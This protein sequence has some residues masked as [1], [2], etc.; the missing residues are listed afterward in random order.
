MLLGWDSNPKNDITG[1]IMARISQ[2]TAV[3]DAYYKLTQNPSEIEE[4]L[5]ESLSSNASNQKGDTSSLDEL[6]ELISFAKDEVQFLNKAKSAFNEVYS[7]LEG[8]HSYLKSLNHQN[9][10]E[11]GRKSLKEKLDGYISEINLV[12]ENSNQDNF[13][14]E[15]ITYI[16]K[17]TAVD[18]NDIHKTL[19]DYEV[20]AKS[21]LLGGLDSNLSTNE[22]I[23]AKKI[24]ISGHRGSVLNL[25]QSAGESAKTLAAEIAAKS[26][27]I[28]V[29]VE[30]RN[31]L[32]IA[33]LSA[34]GTFSFKLTNERTGNSGHTISGINIT[35][36]ANLTPLYNAINNSYSSTAV[37]AEISSQNS[38]V[39][40]IDDTGDTINLTSITEAAGVKTFN[41]F[42][43]YRKSSRD[44]ALQD[45]KM[46]FGN[47]TEHAGGYVEFFGHDK[48]NIEN[49]SIEK[50]DTA[51][52]ILGKISIVGDQVS[53]GT[54]I[55]S[56]PIGYIHST[57]NGENGARLR[58]KF[59]ETIF[60]N[61]D[62][63]AGNI[64]D[65]TVNGW[66]IGNQ[67][68]VFGTDQIGGLNTPSDNSYPLNNQGQLDAGNLA[69]GTFAS[70]LVNS[71]QA[72]NH[73]KSLK[74]ES[75]NMRTTVYGVQHGG[76][77]NQIARGPFVVSN[78]S[79]FLRAGEEVSF[80]WKATGGADAYDVYGYL[81]NS[82]TN[83]FITILNQ[84]GGDNGGGVSY[85]ASTNWAKSSTDITTSGNYKF[86]FASGTYDETGGLVMG[87][88]LEIDNIEITPGPTLSV[89]NVTLQKIADKITLEHLTTD[90]EDQ[91]KNPRIESATAPVGASLKS[92]SI[93]N[94]PA[95]SLAGAS[96]GLA[97]THTITVAGIYDTVGESIDTRTVTISANASAKLVSEQLNAQNINTNVGFAAKTGMVI[98]AADA[99]YNDQISFKLSNNN[100]GTADIAANI[101][102]TNLN[103]LITAI[104]NQTGTTGISATTWQGSNATLLLTHGSGEDIA[105]GELQGIGVNIQPTNFDNTTLEAGT[106][107]IT[108]QAARA[109]MI[110]PITDD[111]RVKITAATGAI[112]ATYTITGKNLAGTNITEAVTASGNAT[113]YS[114]NSFSTVTQVQLSSPTSSN[115]TVGIA[116]DNDGIS[117][118]SPVGTSNLSISGTLVSSGTA[119]LETGEAVVIDTESGTAIRNFTIYGNNAQGT[120]DSEVITSS[121]GSSVSTSK[122][123]TTVTRI[124]IDGDLSGR[125]K[126]GIGSNL[127]GIATIQNPGI[128][129]TNLTLNGSISNA[130]PSGTAVLVD[131]EAV[132]ISTAANGI[133][134]AYT[135]SGKD[136]LGNSQTEVISAVRGATRSG[137]SRFLTVSQVAV[138][139]ISPEGVKIG[140]D[141]DVD[142]I[143]TEADYQAAG[144]AS[145]NGSFV[146]GSTATLNDSDYDLAI[147]GTDREGNAINE[148]VNINNASTVETTNKFSTITSIGVTGSGGNTGRLR[149]FA[150]HDGS[151]IANSQVPNSGANM[152]LT[153][154]SFQN[155]SGVVVGALEA[156]S[157]QRFTITS[158][159]NYHSLSNISDELDPT[160]YSTPVPIDTAVGLKVSTNRNHEIFSTGELLVSSN[161]Q[162][163]IK[164]EDAANELKQVTI[165]SDSSSA[166]VNFT[167]TGTDRSGKSLSETITSSS[168]ATVTG[169][170]SFAIITDVSVDA[171][172]VGNVQVGTYLDQDGIAQSQTRNSAGSLNMNGD[173]I[174][175]GQAVLIN[176]GST[177]FSNATNQNEILLENFSLR[178]TVSDQEF[179]LRYKYAMLDMEEA[180]STIGYTLYNEDSEGSQDSIGSRGSSETGTTRA[181]YSTLKDKEF[182][183]MG[184]SAAKKVK[185]LGSKEL[186]IGN[187]YAQKGN[188]YLLMTSQIAGFNSFNFKGNFDLTK[189]KSK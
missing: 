189:I 179:T 58:V 88:N 21:R 83:A 163:T 103:N 159:N 48:A 152:T 177:F 20:Q 137:S 92:K 50:S 150:E 129:P 155:D 172:L 72:G 75:D 1:Y 93:V 11:Q 23:N 142:G 79:L 166:S 13:S 148:T 90:L 149:I 175:V 33:D 146:S 60:P 69:S 167:I 52:N 19:S 82:D 153:G 28:G 181:S 176:D 17:I 162:F 80:D 107:A 55:D 32:S 51:S 161:K 16:K 70:E 164:Q 37:R 76:P 133:T 101:T 139:S 168:N 109:L 63:E 65:T 22:I 18:I 106:N 185:E 25:T 99:D 86:V 87:A 64:G 156:T 187:I 6:T 165:T 73:G 45:V 40:M 118:D 143:S 89:N 42:S 34:T 7:I 154:V 84:T 112:T 46:N 144:N 26:D 24:D 136:K 132:T 66:T 44:A 127:N 95:T 67:Q 3:M 10:T 2:T 35:D 102:S 119:F 113:T 74:M 29:Y 38:L 30:A 9:V 47:D 116:S 178:N 135:V 57:I 68:V 62:F 97:G 170:T 98:S 71:N 15:L 12:L 96:G 8:A 171:D 188:L 169:S 145:L 158:N 186:L 94:G 160:S 104:N 85:P 5:V 105:I 54:G 56:S 140:S 126:A 53:I 128:S 61:G 100:G 173:K 182:F 114:T 184:Q 180:L 151:S 174:S 4:E 14:P 130:T 131:G 111:Q 123:F 110:D 147:V 134:A 27:D 121:P 59:Y 39:S 81:V 77:G 125:V 108:I 91:D 36:K 31:T 43:E 124:A 41:V 78:N 120:A 115:T 122:N 157:N 117:T 183:E 141:I 49:I 138:N